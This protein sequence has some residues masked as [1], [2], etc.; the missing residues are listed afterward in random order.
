MHLQTDCLE[1]YYLSLEDVY[2]A[3]SR[4]YALVTRERDLIMKEDVKNLAEL[5]LE[6]EEFLGTMSECKDKACSAL[7][8]YKL[9]LGY[10]GNEDVPIIRLMGLMPDE[11]RYRFEKLVAAMKNY[12]AGI[13]TMSTI[14]RKLVSD[15]M[16]FINFVIDFMKKSDGEIETYSTR[17]A[18]CKKSNE[19]NFLDISL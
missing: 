10:N 16:K 4:L 6:K 7:F 8:E 3:Y 2:S 13:K 5:I 1:K 19:R 9:S 14:N 15:T 12:S 18:I 11:W 17:G